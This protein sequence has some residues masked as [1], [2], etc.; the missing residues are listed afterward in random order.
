MEDIKR[1]AYLKILHYALIDIRSLS[2]KHNYSPFKPWTWPESVRKAERINKISDAFH[3]LPLLI[4]DDRFDE[5]SFWREL[6]TILPDK[7]EYLREEY[8]EILSSQ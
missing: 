1:L 4:E 7:I 2:Y 8:E 3:N 5:E 6:S